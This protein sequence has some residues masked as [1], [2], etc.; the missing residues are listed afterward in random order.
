MTIRKCPICGQRLNIQRTEWT[1]HTHQDSGHSIATIGS[2]DN[3][4]AHLQS[5]V[6]FQIASNLAAY[7]LAYDARLN[8]GFRGTAWVQC[9]QARGHITEV[10]LTN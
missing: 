8:L 6:R 4:P 7:E 1:L 5:A 3:A 10:A 9:P 2:A